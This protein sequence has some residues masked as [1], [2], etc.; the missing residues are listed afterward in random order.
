MDIM[1]PGGGL[2]AIEQIMARHPVPVVVVTA[3]IP[4]E[5]DLLFEALSRGALDVAVK[6]AT[7]AEAAALR[8]AVRRFAGVPVVRH[9]RAL[10]AGRAAA[11]PARPL[12]DAA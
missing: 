2:A 5:D 8:T 12:S 4:T 6:P 9:V 7:P 1:M 11:G 3:L 10:R